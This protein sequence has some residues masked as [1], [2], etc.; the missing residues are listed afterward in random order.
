[1]SGSRVER[2]H[3]AFHARPFNF[4][5]KSQYVCQFTQMGEAPA[6]PVEPWI[7]VSSRGHTVPCRGPPRAPETVDSHRDEPAAGDGVYAA[8]RE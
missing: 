8:V 1:M 5:R 4:T 3:G 7:R 2:S 6:F